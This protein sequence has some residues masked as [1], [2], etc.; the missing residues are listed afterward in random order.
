MTGS[1]VNRVHDRRND[2]DHHDFGYALWRLVRFE[3]RQHFD[4]DPIQ[5]QVRGAGDHVAA[6]VPLSIAGPVLVER[7]LFQQRVA[8]AHGE[9]A[10]RLADDD[11]RHQRI[12]AFE[13]RCSLWRCAVGRWRARSRRGPSWRTRRCRRG[14]T[15][16]SR[17]AEISRSTDRGTRICR[18]PCARPAH[19]YRRS[20]SVRRSGNS[21]AT[22]PSARRRAPWLPSRHDAHGLWRRSR[23]TLAAPSPA[24]AGC[25]LSSAPPPTAWPR[26]GLA[27][28]PTGRALPAIGRS[29]I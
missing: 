3:R 20:M 25:R 2:R 12:A 9:A 21:L 28:Y 5:R 24:S 10:L 26:D 18:C 14:R 4:L 1:V 15:G 19:R 17:S 16:C 8:H 29:G 22:T 13:A 11:F 6:E 7:Q 27:Q 23:A